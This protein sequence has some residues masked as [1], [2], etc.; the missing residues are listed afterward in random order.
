M[1]HSQ[2]DFHRRGVYR[3]RGTCMRRLQFARRDSMMLNEFKKKGSLP[4]DKNEYN[5][6][7]ES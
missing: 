6:G 7:P 3:C 1:R 5:A 2:E 4:S